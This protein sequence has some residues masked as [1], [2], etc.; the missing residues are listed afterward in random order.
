[1]NC[2]EPV[3]NCMSPFLCSLSPSLSLSCSL[4]YFF[5]FTCWGNSV[6][7]ITY[8]H[9]MKVLL[10]VAIIITIIIIIKLTFQLVV[11]IRWKHCLRLL[12]RIWLFLLPRMCPARKTRVILWQVNLSFHNTW[13]DCATEPTIQAWRTEYLTKAIVKR[14]L[15]RVTK[16]YRP[17]VLHC[18]VDR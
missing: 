17:P 14:H 16:G 18:S 4:L 8:P 13:V 7:I 15:N 6:S 9:V 10:T 2:S 5:L 3:K 12:S 11:I 1:M